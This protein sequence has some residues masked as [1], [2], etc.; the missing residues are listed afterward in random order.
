LKIFKI[1]C[2]HSPKIHPKKKALEATH[3]KVHYIILYNQI[4]A[5]SPKTLQKP[6]YNVIHWLLILGRSFDSHFD[7]QLLLLWYG[8][9]GLW[10]M[11]LDYGLKSIWLKI[12]PKSSDLQRGGQE[13]K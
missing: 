6:S 4:L 9:V 8:G 5:V 1:V 2:S 13:T 11:W 10:C 3:I 12:R 7:L